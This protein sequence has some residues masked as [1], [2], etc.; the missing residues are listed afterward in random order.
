VREIGRAGEVA[1]GWRHEAYGFH[2]HE[3]ASSNA[4]ATSSMIALEIRY[5]VI[6]RVS[7]KKENARHDRS[8]QAIIF[9]REPDPRGARGP[10]ARATRAPT[11]AFARAGQYG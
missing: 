5:A 10:R 8:L 11:G 4:I 1:T 2:A 3:I 9:G 6:H 7:S